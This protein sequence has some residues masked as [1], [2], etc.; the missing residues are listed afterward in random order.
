MTLNTTT[1]HISLFQRT[2]DCGDDH[3]PDRY[4]QADVVH[5]ILAGVEGI[6]D[7]SATHFVVIFVHLAT[8]YIGKGPEPRE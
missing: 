4:S 2:E 1:R 3:H 8:E 7:G 6:G 5:H